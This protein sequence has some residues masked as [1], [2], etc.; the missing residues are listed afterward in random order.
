MREDVPAHEVD[1][2]AEKATRY[3]VVVCVINEGDRILRQ[4]ARMAST[5]GMPDVVLADGGSDDGSMDRGHLR[6]LGVRAL[7]TKLGPGRLGAQQRMAFAWCL[8]EG[9]DGVVT[10]DGNG[11]DGVGA[12][13]AF[14]K[15]LDSGYDFVQGSR[16]R[17][18]GSSR[19]TPVSRWL[20][21]RLVHAPWI[22]LLAGER[23]TDTT[24]A[25]RGYSR[26]YLE[27]PDVQPFRDVFT[28]YEL[29]AY[30][31]VR[32]SQLGLRTTEVPVVREYPRTG[33]TPTKISPLHGN[34]D[35]LKVLWRLSRR[36]FHPSG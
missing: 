25:F 3:A 28:G 9:Y 27:H 36:Q 17:P 32:A 19:N 34:L 20:A 31:S 24:N 30:L 6:E 14:V 23:F 18:G 15:A 22:S 12:V 1:V 16:F 21:L 13:P 26:A 11:K 33:R 29:L 4:L 2:F 8:R 5:P 7:L 10:V 35:L